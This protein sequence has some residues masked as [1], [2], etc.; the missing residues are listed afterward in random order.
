MSFIKQFPFGLAVIFLTAGCFHKS[1]TTGT[2]DDI[3][4]SFTCHTPK[5]DYL[6]THEEIFHASSKSSG[7]KGT[8]ISGSTDYRYTVRDLQT[9]AQVTRLVTGDRDEDLFPIGYDGKQLWCY[10]PDKKIGLHTREPLTMAVTITLEQ[11]EKENP[12]LAGN[13]NMPKIYEAPQFYSYDPVSSSII[14]TDLQGI[15]YSLDPKTLKATPI[16]KKP[17]FSNR[18]SDGHSSNA[19]RSNSVRIN[20]SGEL[21]KQVDLGRDNKSE[22]SYLSGE[23]LLEQ[24][25]GRLGAIAAQ[26]MQ[27]NIAVFQKQQQEYDSLLKLYPVLKDQRQA[28]LNI[29][30]YHI[31]DHF[32]DLQSNLSSKS[33]DSASKSNDIISSLSNMALGGD[34]NTVYILHA[35]NL[36]DTGSTLISKV[37][38][39]ENKAVTLWTSMIPQI[40][41]NPSKGIKR[42][43]MADV[44]KSGNPQFSYEWYGVEGNVLVGIK[45]LFAFGIDTNTGKLLWKQQL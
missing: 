30:D 2:A 33:R 42:N 22:E 5:G 36:T 3:H 40:Y 24:N 15:F 38:I 4:H 45:M 9:G 34:S 41:F 26:L 14:F 32:Y 6:I 39:K 31:I 10:S 43:S 11:L 29:K 17:S 16:K 7:P 35:N 20:L 12:P 25:T 44:F 37:S 21:R 1:N 23:I 28:Y 19:L 8:F 18:F 27:A 13:I